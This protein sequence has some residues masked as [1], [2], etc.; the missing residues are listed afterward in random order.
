MKILIIKP[1]SFGDIIQANPV[2]LALRR[3]Y[4]HAHITWLVFD[5]WADVLSCFPEIDEVMVWKKSGGLGDYFDII[6]RIRA[7]KF[8]IVIDL[9]GLART[10]VL[11]RLSGAKVRIGVPGLKECSWLLEKEVF[12]ESAG[13]N[14]AMRNLETVR[15]LSGKPQEVVFSL[16]IKDVVIQ[17]ADRIIKAAGT[18]ENDPLIALVPS[19]RG[20]G[21]EWPVG[22][23]RELLTHIF[24]SRPNAKVLMLGGK[25]DFYIFSGK[26]SIALCGKTSLLQLFGLLKRCKVV[27]GPD[28][29]PIHLAA[30]LG[31]PVVVLFGGSD[32]NETAPAVEKISI[33][34]KDYPC[35][36]C[37]GHTTCVGYPCLRDIAPQEVMEALSK[38]L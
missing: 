12:P 22:H 13:I 17:E 7:E 18:L 38:W 30:A 8:D 28:T 14:A 24:V 37:R 21:K 11:S 33:L 4:P 32:V 1:S 9:Q 35:S 26:G 16:S 2:A 25:G 29:G 27:V 36:P 23:F 15:F 31:V 19:S 3:S 20:K 10:G 5:V 6:S 34:K